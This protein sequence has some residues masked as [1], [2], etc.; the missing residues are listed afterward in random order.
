MKKQP[1]QQCLV[2]TMLLI[3]LIIFGQNAFANE[4]ITIATATHNLTEPLSFFTH[5]VY[6][7][8]YILAIVLLGSTIAQYRAH[9]LNPNQTPISRPIVLLLLTLL[10]AVV[11]LLAKLSESAQ[12]AGN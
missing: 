2:H 6:N 5:T 4:H 8:C 12:Y 3:A 10:T 9:R 11:P 1:F 7:I